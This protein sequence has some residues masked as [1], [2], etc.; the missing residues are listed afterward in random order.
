MSF[1]KARC[2]SK[3]YPSK[4]KSVY[5]YLQT[6]SI[7]SHLLYLRLY[8]KSIFSRVIKKTAIFTILFFF[9]GEVATSGAHRGSIPRLGVKSEL[10][11]VTYTTATE[12]P[13]PSHICALHHSSRHHQILNPLSEAHGCQSDSFLLDHDENSFTSLFKRCFKICHIP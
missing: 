4:Y 5:V 7:S 2:H 11:L 8:L 6:L 12:M 1:L 3:F 13:D 10:Q 9:G